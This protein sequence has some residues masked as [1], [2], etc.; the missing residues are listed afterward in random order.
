MDQVEHRKASLFNYHDTNIIAL[1][2]V[3]GHSMEK[4]PTF[5]SALV[6][7]VWYE[8]E[9]D[10]SACEHVDECLKYFYVRTIYNDEVLLVPPNCSVSREEA[11][12]MDEW[13]SFVLSQ[14]SERDES[15]CEG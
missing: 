15:L 4:W 5:A 10:F 14:I 1:V 3:L 7:E 9:R 13:R 12:R 2:G 6:F 11:C 8:E